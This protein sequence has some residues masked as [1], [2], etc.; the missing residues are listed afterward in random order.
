MSATDRDTGLGTTYERIAVA[1]MLEALV[2]RYRIARVLEGPSDGIT[3]IRGLNSVPLAQAGAS[4][5][6]VLSDPA[7]VDLAR[8]VW[9]RLGLADR[10][11]ARATSDFRLAAEPKAFDLVW[12]FNS[13]PQVPEPREL[14][15][16]MCGASRQL[17]LVFTS[18]TWN[19]GFPIHRL[20]HRVAH[21][22]W[23]HGNPS[24]MSPGRIARLLSDEGFEVVERMLVDVPWWP[25]IDSPIEEVLASFLPFL[26]R[27][28]GASKRLERYT[29]TAPNLPYFDPERRTALL[30]DI[31]RHFAIEDASWCPAKPLFA[32]HRGILARRGER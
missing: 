8:R 9:E 30:A 2:Q 26:R 27:R 15:R 16:E 7:E 17:V 18:N 4:V 23:D 11:T 24:F 3:G 1:R 12:N 32:H 13:I 19:Y 31:G 5:E 20:H 28:V 21:E 25:D 22:E 14:V 29:W 6:L 10:L